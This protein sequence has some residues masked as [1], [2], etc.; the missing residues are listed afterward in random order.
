MSADLGQ[1]RV[2][3]EMPLVHGKRRAIGQA[4][5]LP[6][7]GTYAGRTPRV[8]DHE[9]VAD[10]PGLRYERGA[11]LRFQMAVEMARE[12]TRHRPGCK[13]Q[14]YSIASHHRD[15][16]DLGVQAAQRPFTLLNSNPAARKL[17]GEYTG[18]RTNINEG[19]WRKQRK[20]TRD[21][22]EFFANGLGRD[23]DAEATE[24]AAR[25]RDAPLVTRCSSVVV[26]PQRRAIAE[27][28]RHET[29]VACP[30]E[31]RSRLRDRVRRSEP[32]GSYGV[33]GDPLGE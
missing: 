10:T 20:L 6:L 25:P 3:V 29:S 28:R 11:L 13:R 23:L 17:R 27:R 9:F 2:D 32:I 4:T 24:V 30:T 33:P 22:V 12:H 26:R 16:R 8:K 21:L 15:F 1:E 19:R 31:Q 14:G 18:T 7:L 5:A